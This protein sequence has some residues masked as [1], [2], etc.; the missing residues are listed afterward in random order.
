[1]G[2]LVAN[3]VKTLPSKGFTAEILVT[4]E[5]LAL[6]G[7]A[8]EV[9]DPCVLAVTVPG[10]L[11]I[12]NEGVASAGSLAAVLGGAEGAGAGGGE[13]GSGGESERE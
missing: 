11:G 8:V 1:M 10:P 4:S 13:R 2:V 12:R 6:V 9:S 3:N 7:S 5:L